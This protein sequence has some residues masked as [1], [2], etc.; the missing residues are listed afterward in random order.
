[1][2]DRVAAKDIPV[3]HLGRRRMI[4]RDDLEACIEERTV[5]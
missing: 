2:W 4:R 5:R 3:V 1:M